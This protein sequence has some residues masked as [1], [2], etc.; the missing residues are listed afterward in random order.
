MNEIPNFN[1]NLADSPPII[2]ELDTP[3]TDRDLALQTLL[4]TDYEYARMIGLIDMFYYDPVTGE[5]GLMHTLVGNVTVG[6]QGAS[7]PEGFHHE[8]SVEILMGTDSGQAGQETAQLLPTRVDREHLIGA[9][10]RA[11]AEFKELP[12]EPYKAKVIINNQKKL[13][14]EKN[15]ETG[16][17]QVVETKNLMYPKEYDPMAVL[18][19]IRIASENLESPDLELTLDQ[20]GNHAEVCVG[21]VPMLDGETRMRIRLVRDPRTHKIRTAIPLTRPGAMKLSPSDINTH[22][23][24]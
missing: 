10:S 2:T 7:I 3:L 20:H 24:L 4:G 11:K 13:S 21:S 18:Q 9:N 16:T 6:D 14:I 15:P 19:A 12:F 8:P 17:E 22:L 1:S 23:G 5:D